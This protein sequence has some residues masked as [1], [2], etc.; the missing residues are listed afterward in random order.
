MDLKDKIKV[1]Q[2]YADGGD[3]QVFKSNDK[4]WNDWDRSFG[5]PWFDWARNEYRIKPEKKKRLMTAEEL[6]GKVI[7]CEYHRTLMR[8]KGVYRHLVSSC[9]EESVYMPHMDKVWVE[10]KGLN[11]LGWTLEDGSPLTVEVGDE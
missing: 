10:I 2:H 7:I 11:D 9:D 1:M 5:V 8:E 3:I 4:K 6:I